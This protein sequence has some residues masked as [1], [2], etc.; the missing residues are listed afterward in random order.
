MWPASAAA[1]EWSWPTRS[2]CA[3]RKPLP[4]AAVVALLDEV[5]APGLQAVADALMAEALAGMTRCIPAPA[6]V[7]VRPR[8][9]GWT[10]DP[11]LRAMR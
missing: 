8:W 5:T 7:D 10:A 2:D 9:V 6:T 11:A 3:A 4:A 1:S